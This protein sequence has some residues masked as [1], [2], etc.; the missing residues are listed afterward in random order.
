MRGRTFNM[1]ALV[2]LIVLMIARI[3]AHPGCA[4]PAESGGIDRGNVFS[5]PRRDQP[6]GL[7]K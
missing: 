2:M 6:A 1:R 7:L 3:A 4:C 5:V